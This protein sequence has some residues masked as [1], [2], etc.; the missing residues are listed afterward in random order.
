[1]KARLFD[2][3][4]LADE[5]KLASQRDLILPLF[6]GHT[7]QVAEADE[8]M[9]CGIDVFLHQHS[10]GMKAVEQ[11]MRMQLAL[12][13]L[14][15]SMGKLRLQLRSHGLAFQRNLVE[16]DRLIQSNNQP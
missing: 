10:N 14:Q 16:V 9:A 7:E 1:M 8:Q 2:L 4:I 3:Q 13:V 15:F 5:G 6:E 11:K 12:Q